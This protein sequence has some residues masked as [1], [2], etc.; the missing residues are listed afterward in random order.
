MDH[1]GETREGRHE[2]GVCQSA[3]ASD[4][5]GARFTI[6]SGVPCLS[7]AASR[8]DSRRSSVPYADTSSGAAFAGAATWPFSCP[9]PSR[10][11]ASSS[12]RD[13]S[14]DP[15]GCRAFSC[16]ARWSRTWT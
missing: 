11:S 14:R 4:V 10:Y 16:A 6:W 15:C 9:H 1:H 7:S 3:Y 8:G 13:S 5:G 12:Y 2:R